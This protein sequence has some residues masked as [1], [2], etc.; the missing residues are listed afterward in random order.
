MVIKTAQ[1]LT[2]AFI[3]KAINEKLSQNH[4][5]QRLQDYYEGKQ[6]ILMRRYDDP[7]KPNNRIVVNYCKKIADFM[8]AYLVGVPIRFEAPQVILDSL[9]YNDQADTQQEIVKNMNIMG[10]GCEL[11][12]TDTDGIPRF[13]SIDPRE[14]IFI[15][16][17]SVEGVLTAYIR[18]YADPDKIDGYYVTV[19]TVVEVFS[20]VLSLSVSELKQLEAPQKHFFDDVPAI[21][22]LNN[23]EISGS[24]E[25]IM[26]LQ[27]ALNKLLS[28]ELND[29]ESFVDAYLVLTG[30]QATTKEDIAK[31]KQDRVLLLDSESAAQWL[32]KDVN[33]A[34]IKE[35][36]EGITGE[37]HRL[38]NIPD[39]ENLGSFGTSGIALRY[40]LLS[41][42]IAASRQ[43]RVVHRG[44]QRKL[45]LLYS[46][47]R[48]TD[49]AIG[50]YTDVNIIFER[51]FIM[52]TEDKLKQ[53][54]LDLS[55]VERHILSKETFLMTYRDMTPEEAHA[56][57]HKVAV[58]SYKDDIASDFTF[59]EYSLPRERTE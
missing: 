52:L 46:I 48:I 5:L 28:D 17:D 25:G 9:N 21:M 58:E 18:V 45:E 7:T 29:F 13:A 42:E 54:M 15:T 11:F 44:L 8:T 34:H 55:L 31:M 32:I 20:Y 14:S 38:G 36:K 37:I 56:E 53:Q 12:Y 39:I 10:L 19:Y 43:E 3:I 47:F 24:F 26:S 33:N 27:D 59:D 50:E 35:L 57:L 4:R 1:S 30:L 6:D 22:Y 2:N 41:T 49:P 40:K 23:R 16:D 51:N